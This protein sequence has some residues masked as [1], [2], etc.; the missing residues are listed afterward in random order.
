M[1]QYY[2]FTLDGKPMGYFEI[3]ERRAEIYMNARI[4]ID[5]E[6]QE[7]P[8]TVRVAGGQPTHVRLGDTEWKP[9]PGGTYPTCAYLL[10]LRS[11]LPRYRAFIEGTGE[12]EDREIR[13]EDGLLVEYA[14]GAFVRRFRMQG[15]L[16]DY[17][18][19]GGT[20]ESQLVGSRSAAV[21]GTVF[22]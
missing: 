4:C 12:I 20:A 15:E 11:G 3:D 14:N 21:R 13:S 5:G 9:V 2:T 8:F 18:C 16:V 19:W 22:E 1:L 6:R 17:I 7:N 10:V